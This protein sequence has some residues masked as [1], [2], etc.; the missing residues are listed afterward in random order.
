MSIYS[1]LLSYCGQFDFI[2]CFCSYIGLNMLKVIKQMNR[3]LGCCHFYL[4]VVTY[5]M[6]LTKGS[7]VLKSSSLFLFVH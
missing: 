2:M 7:Y 5:G 1:P 3:V 4:R 6:F